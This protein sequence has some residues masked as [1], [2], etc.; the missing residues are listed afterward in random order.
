MFKA[1]L[2][3]SKYWKNIFE[4]INAIIVET[5]ILITPTEFRILAMDSV[6][7]TMLALTLKKEDFDV[8]D[9]PDDANYSIGVNLSDLLKI[10]KRAGSDDNIIFEYNPADRHIIVK[11]NRPDSKK[12]KKFSLS[13][14]DL[15]ATKLTLQQ[16]MEIPLHVVLNIDSRFISEAINR[17]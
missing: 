14:I 9:C 3:D 17:R 8:Y 12:T 6:H 10:L 1:Q 13:L 2:K 11:M 7:V 16:L 4:A 5:N 15:D